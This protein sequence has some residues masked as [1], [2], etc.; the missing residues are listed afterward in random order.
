M[1]T[2]F[3]LGDESLDVRA[4]ADREVPLKVAQDARDGDRLRQTLPS[5]LLSMG[6]TIW[7]YAMPMGWGWA[8][9][10]GLV[11][12]IFIH[13][14]GH[15][16]AARRYGLP[17]RG[18]RFIPLVGGVVFHQQGNTTVTENA[19]IGIMGPVF[20]TLVAVACAVAYH[21]TREPF[22]HGIAHLN[23]MMNAAN[24]LI[25]APPLDGHWLAAVFSKKSSATKAEKI[26]WALAWAGLGLFLV[27]GA[28]LL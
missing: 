15:A 25:P 1:P 18:M 19:F 8:V 7:F 28:L 14:C 2:K 17:Y 11:F 3:D 27:A 4:R 5:T 16:L 20:G 10:A 9:A 6:F 13:E 12:S 26:K 22:W 24:L 23:F 21:F